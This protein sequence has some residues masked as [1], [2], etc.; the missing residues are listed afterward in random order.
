MKTRVKIIRW[1]VAQVG[2]AALYALTFATAWV[3]ALVFAL[4]VPSARWNV[5]SSWGRIIQILSTPGTVLAGDGEK[6]SVN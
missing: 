3:F 1:L 2:I 5:V 6:H 4:V